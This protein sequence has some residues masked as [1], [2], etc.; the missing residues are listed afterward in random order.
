M[1]MSESVYVG[2]ARKMRKC[3]MMRGMEKLLIYPPVFILAST[4][5]SMVR[6]D[7]THTAYLFVAGSRL[8]LV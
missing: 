7:F 1:P 6:Y 4:Q 3:S 5:Q 8:A 2:I